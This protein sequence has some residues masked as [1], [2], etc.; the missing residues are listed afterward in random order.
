ME[1]SGVMNCNG[2]ESLSTQELMD[3]IKTRAGTLLDT[4]GVGESNKSWA[5]DRCMEQ[6]RLVASAVEAFKERAKK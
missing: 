3:L 2:Y 1:R 6:L 5:A 4:F